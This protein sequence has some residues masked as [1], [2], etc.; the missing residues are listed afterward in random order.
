M[1]LLCSK[2]PSDSPSH[3]QIPEALQ[4]KLIFPFSPLTTTPITCLTSSPTLP[5][6]GPLTIPQLLPPSTQPA[7]V[8]CKEHSSSTALISSNYVSDVTYPDH[9]FWNCTPL[10]LTT[11]PSPLLCLIF[12]SLLFITFYHIIC[13]VYL[14][15]LLFISL[16]DIS[17]RFT[18][19][20]IW[21][22]C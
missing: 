4:A 19:S 13:F 17:I 12:F 11:Y 16:P 20:G 6:T 1:S 15:S 5:H 18:W 21:L 3:E 9:S 8:P 10:P 22:F 14:F 2:H 7:L